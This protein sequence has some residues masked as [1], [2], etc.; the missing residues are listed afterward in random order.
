MGRMSEACCG[1]T[2]Y[3]CTLHSFYWVTSPIHIARH[4]TAYPSVLRYSSSS[5]SRCS[6]CGGDVGG[7]SHSSSKYMIWPS[8]RMWHQRHRL[9]VNSLWTTSDIVVVLVVVVV[10]ICDA[11]IRY[12]SV[13]S[14]PWQTL[15]QLTLDNE[16]L[17]S[18][19]SCSSSSNS[20]LWC[21]DQVHR[22]DVNTVTNFTTTHFGQ[23]ATL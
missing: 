16:Q 22:C 5:S 20:S 3:R 12:T 9:Y 15:L 19:I 6:S 17:C 1:W 2:H 7:C 18:S 13:M 8:K 11:L 4:A 14:T 10:V 21:I 23:R